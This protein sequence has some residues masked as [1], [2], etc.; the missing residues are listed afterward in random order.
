MILSV[1]KVYHYI[2][3]NS[4]KINLNNF[5]IPID[6]INILWYTNISGTANEC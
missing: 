4:L 2:Y 1:V 3:L 6:T 5:K